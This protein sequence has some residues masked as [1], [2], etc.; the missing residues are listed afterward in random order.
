MVTE[1]ELIPSNR[2]N[3]WQSWKID[4]KEY[5]LFEDKDG[6]TYM[7]EIIKVT[8]ETHN[9]YYAYPVFE[10]GELVDYKHH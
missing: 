8:I 9:K 7:R 5:K 6:N 3:M 4:G 1:E 2:T 10:L